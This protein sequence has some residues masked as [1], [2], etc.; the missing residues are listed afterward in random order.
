MSEAAYWGMVR[1]G[2]RRTF[3]WWKPALKALEA[4]RTA[5]K[6]PRGQKWSYKCAKCK[7]QFLRK[8]VQIDH[9]VP[10]GTL[11]SYKDVGAWLKRL[12]PEDTKA[13]A[14]RCKECHKEKT[15]TERENR[16]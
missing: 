3:R 2:L 8:D 5:C 7:K 15:K 9:I 14:V 1:S 11:L 6:G 16:K 4:A 12:T 10:V 13:F